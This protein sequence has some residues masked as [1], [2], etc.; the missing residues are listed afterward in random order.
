[1]ASA[2]QNVTRAVARKMFAP[3]ALAPI[4]P[5]RARKSKEAPDTMGTSAPVG[6]TTTMSKGIAAPTAN[7]AADVSAACTGR[8]AVTSEIPSSSRA[9]AARASFVVSCWATRRARRGNDAV[10]GP[11][12]YGSQPQNAVDKVVFRVQAKPTHGFPLITPSRFITVAP[13]FEKRPVP[14][15]QSDPKI[16]HRRRHQ[17][18]KKARAK[19]PTSPII[20]D[21]PTDSTVCLESDFAEW[22]RG[23]FSRCGLI[24][25]NKVERHIF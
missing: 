15:E 19:W 25:I 1:M 24:Q 3:P 2:P 14:G 21:L 8:A 20:P 12:H 10:I 18:P 16:R 17:Y 7:D 11:K 23:W 9:W 13:I 5:R 6:D 22:V 4:A